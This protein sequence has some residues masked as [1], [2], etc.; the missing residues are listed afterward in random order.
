MSQ[1]GVRVVLQ[2][3]LLAQALGAVPKLLDIL[4]IMADLLVRTVPTEQVLTIMGLAS[5]QTMLIAEKRIMTEQILATLHQQCSE[6]KIEAGLARGREMQLEQVVAE[7][8][9]VGEQ[10]AQ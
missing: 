8:L 9:L 2:A 6:L 7:M 4:V 1:P 3:L 5:G 10:F